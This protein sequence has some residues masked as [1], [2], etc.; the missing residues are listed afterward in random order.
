MSKEKELAEKLHALERK[1]L[2]AL[3]DKTLSV[4]ELAAASGLKEAN[5][6]RALL[7]L[8]SK[9]LIE[10]SEKHKR[11]YTLTELG[12][13]Y[14]KI[15]LPEE[16]IFKFLRGVKKI[17]ICE[18]LNSGSIEKDEIDIAIGTLKRNGIIKLAENSIELIR[19]EFPE[20]QEKRKVLRDISEGVIPE[21][22][23]LHEMLRRGIVQKVEKVERSVTITML[24]REV[25]KW[26]KEGKEIDQLT[27]QLILSG[28]WKTMKFRKY[29]IHSPAPKLFPGRINKYIRFINSIKRALLGLGFQ[30][31][32]GP[33]VEM[34]FFNCDLLFMPQDHPAR[35]IHNIFF[36]KNPSSGDLKEFREMLKRVRKI[37]EQSWGISFS[38][39]FSRR[40]VL[41]SHCTAVSIRKLISK[42]DIP[43]K[44][45]TI[46]RCY[47]PDVLSWK[48]LPEFFQLDGIVIGKEL[49]FRNLIY[50]LGIFAELCGAEAYRI[51]PAYF[52]FTEPSAEVAMYK[53]GFGW[54][55]I[56]GAG[57]LRPEVLRPIGIK[58]EVLA[59]GLG[60]DRMFMLKEGFKDIRNVFSRDLR[61]LIQN[62]AGNR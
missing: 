5:V 18:L 12:R 16:R 10:V 23:F 42:L 50:I 30:E 28:K 60:L 58:E 14:L 3:S 19:D 13:R 39:E 24:G 53:E 2:K 57:M 4:E 31:M 34:N 17:R 46:G 61:W 7:W 15:G 37:H 51:L 52:P 22:P 27:P 33:I 25:L 56:G 43:G 54:I 44:Y 29:D 49:N 9:G 45:F 35:D 47:R 40:Y 11:I 1:V 21:S 6:E 32:K 59:W 26:V 62:E 48:H 8:K 20:I 38:E 55:E 41:R 36:I